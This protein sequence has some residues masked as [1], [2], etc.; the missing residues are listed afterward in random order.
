M[1][2]L[3]R[4]VSTSNQELQRFQELIAECK[5]LLAGMDTL[6][7]HAL[8][9]RFSAEIDSRQTLNYL[10]DGPSL[11][12]C[13]IARHVVRPDNLTALIAMAEV[14]DRSDLKRSIDRYSYSPPLSSHPGQSIIDEGIRNSIHYLPAEISNAL[15]TS[16]SLLKL[17]RIS[18]MIGEIWH[19]N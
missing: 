16:K 12:T 14:A 17:L 13:L 2:N 7:L 15:S 10:V 1:E 19:V 18:K 8:I 11:L 3:N 5:N 6:Q 9:E 4:T